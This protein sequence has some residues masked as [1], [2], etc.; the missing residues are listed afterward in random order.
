[1]YPVLS[2]LQLYISFIER[3][4]VSPGKI[5]RKTTEKGDVTTGRIFALRYSSLEHAAVSSLFVRVHISLG[6]IRTKHTK[7]RGLRGN[8]YIPVVPVH[9]AW[10][11]NTRFG[12]AETCGVVLHKERFC[13]STRQCRCPSLHVRETIHYVIS[14]NDECHVR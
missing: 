4:C 7:K 9:T 11:H 8:V 10:S 2:Q 14:T 5:L 6:G 3:K 13:T 1:M 12:P